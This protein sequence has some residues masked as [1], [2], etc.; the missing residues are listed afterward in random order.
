VAPTLGDAAKILETVAI[1]HPI[2]E[3]ERNEHEQALQTASQQRVAQA[4]P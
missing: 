2:P 3:G 4:G 1:Y